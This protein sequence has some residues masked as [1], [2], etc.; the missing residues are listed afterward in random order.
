MR[1]HTARCPLLL[2]IVLAAGCYDL[3]LTKYTGGG[4][5][6]SGLAKEVGGDTATSGGSDAGPPTPDAQA[7]DVQGRD[8]QPLDAPGPDIQTLDAQGPEATLPVDVGVDRVPVG[9]QSDVGTSDAGLAP[10]SATMDGA[11]PQTAPDGD[12]DLRYDTGHDA[13][14]RD[15]NATE[16]R[17]PDATPLDTSTPDTSTPD[18]KVDGPAA[19]AKVM[20]ATADSLTPSLDVGPATCGRIKCDCT[21]NG[22]KLWGNVQYVTMFP[23]FKV[24]VSAFPDLNVNET[25]FGSQCGQW[26]IVTSFPD[27]TVQIVDMF[28]DF[29]IA[30]SSF[31]GIP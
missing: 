12:A 27:F 30:Y 3:S 22:V 2:A 17:A 6:A 5:D 26:H 15:A 19:D 10:D 25:Y 28:E 24:K 23:D 11:A 14:A 9:P 21:F 13:A 7:P 18:A 29:D 16:A 20:D 31:P 4:P 8:A 1:V